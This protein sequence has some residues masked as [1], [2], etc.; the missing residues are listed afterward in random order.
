[1]DI[2]EQK[3]QVYEKAAIDCTNAC[4]SLNSSVCG[5]V[6]SLAKKKQK[7]LLTGEELCKKLLESS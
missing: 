2:I 1:M 4:R 3:A 6:E 7:K 5:L